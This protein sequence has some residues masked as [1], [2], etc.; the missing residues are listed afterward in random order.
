[1]QSSM[2][3][4]KNTLFGIT[5]ALDITEET[6]HESEDVIKASQKETQR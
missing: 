1:M 5:I 6:T 3:E 2:P 4:I